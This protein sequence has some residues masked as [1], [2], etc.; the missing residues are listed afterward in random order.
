MLGYAVKEG[1]SRSCGCLITDHARRM[2]AANKRHG[3]TH[4]T[5]YKIWAMM[6]ERCGNPNATSYTAY[7]G[8]GIAV[9][10]RWANSFEAFYADMGARPSGSHSIDRI[11][12]DLGYEPGNCRWATLI[13]QARNTSA[14]RFLRLGDEVRTVSDW[15]EKLHISRSTLNA[16]I[17]RG[18]TAERALAAQIFTPWAEASL[19]KGES[20]ISKLSALEFGESAAHSLSP[21][22]PKEAD[23]D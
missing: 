5:E 18:W 13:E 14:S 4:S 7:G 20:E 3:M 12:N 8:R 9:C 10:E 22:Q 17:R 23:R 15:A 21:Q 1:H 2:G 11:N 19:R 6:R 16:R